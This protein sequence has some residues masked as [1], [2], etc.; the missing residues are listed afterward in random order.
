MSEHLLWWQHG[1]E[2]EPLEPHLKDGET[3]AE[4]VK[5]NRAEVDLVLG[6][7]AKEK[8]R[9]ETRDALLERAR[10]ELN[11]ALL[12]LAPMCVTVESCQWETR[13]QTLL[14][15]LKK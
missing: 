3:P 5:R 15:E 10:A 11:W 8:A 1:D 12:N 2:R 14:A 7:L 4:C 6:L 13:V 9:V